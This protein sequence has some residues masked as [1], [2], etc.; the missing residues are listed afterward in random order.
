MRCV[1]PVRD[2]SF[3]PELESLVRD[4]VHTLRDY[5]FYID[6]E[7]V[8]VVVCRNCR[9]RALA[10]IHYLPTVWRLVLGLK[11]M[12]VIEVIEG[13][14]NSLTYEEKVRVV[15]HELLHIPKGFSGGLRPHGR[16]VSSYVVERLLKEYFR[17]KSAS[18]R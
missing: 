13:N 15:I 5:F 4:V 8:R 16:Y 3:D 17:R 1:L 9:S 10:R 14:F 11:P 6:V 2:Y 18:K 7:R 12:Y